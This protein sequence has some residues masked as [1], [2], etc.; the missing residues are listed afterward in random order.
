[1]WLRYPA[2]L[3]IV[4]IILQPYFRYSQCLH[5]CP[6]GLGGWPPNRSKWADF[7]DHLSESG[8]KRFRY[9]VA[10]KFLDKYWMEWGFCLAP[11]IWGSPNSDSESTC[12]C[13][14]MHGCAQSRSREGVSR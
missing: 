7:C 14:C 11:P 9:V 10:K 2:G 3:K 6:W 13:R 4:F 5:R 8:K 12:E 1:L